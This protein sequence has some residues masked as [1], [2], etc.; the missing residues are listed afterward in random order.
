MDY[1]S[2]HDMELIYLYIEDIGSA[3][4]NVGI[5]F[6]SGFQVKYHRDMKRLEI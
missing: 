2:R 1:D 5:S 6:G 3:L 4:K